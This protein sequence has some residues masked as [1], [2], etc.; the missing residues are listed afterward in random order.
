MNARKVV[1]IASIVVVPLSLLLDFLPPENSWLNSFLIYALL[2]GMIAHFLITGGHGGTKA[3][4][5][6]APFVGAIVNIAA[7]S[8]LLALIAKWCRRGKSN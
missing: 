7:Y 2:P 3:Q 1:G 6:V 5:A 8:L 4:D